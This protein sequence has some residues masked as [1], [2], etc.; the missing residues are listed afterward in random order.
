MSGRKAPGSNN[1]WSKLHWIPSPDVS[2][3]EVYMLELGKSCTK[4][5]NWTSLSWPFSTFHHLKASIFPL[6]Y[7]FTFSKLGLHQTYLENAALSI[8]GLVDAGSSW[9]GNSSSPTLD[10]LSQYLEV[11]CRNISFSQAL[12]V[13]Y[14]AGEYQ[15]PELNVKIPGIWEISEPIS[16]CH[17]GLNFALVE[18]FTPWKSK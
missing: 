5:T 9:K 3:E 18:V 17:S 2:P 1:F 8:P 14:W 12:R 11:E 6:K 7:L 13:M 15:L 10:I 16:F 4:E